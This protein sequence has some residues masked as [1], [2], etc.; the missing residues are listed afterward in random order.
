MLAAEIA[1][2][3]GAPLDLI[4]VRK[5]GHPHSPEGP[6]LPP[7]LKMDTPLC[8]Y[9]KSIRSTKSGLRRTFESSV[10]EAAV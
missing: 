4:I 2:S 7:W 8:I 10:K 1:R 6:E 3:F 9:L 5:V